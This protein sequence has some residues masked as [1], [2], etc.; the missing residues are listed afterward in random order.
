MLNRE[1][2]ILILLM[3]GVITLTSDL[4]S[5]NS[6]FERASATFINSREYQNGQISWAFIDVQSGETLAS[7]QAEK[8]QIPA[9]TVKVFT[10]AMLLQKL[11]AEATIKTNVFYHG[12]I[13]KHKLKGDIIVRGSGDP[14]L[15]SGLAGSMSGDSVLSKITNALKNLGIHKISG[16]LI[17][18]PY[19]LPYDHTV[20]PR[21]YIWEDI[22]NYYGAASWGLNWR[23]N[24]YTVQ[25]KT[26][27]SAPDSVAANI[28]SPWAN[29]LNL[30]YNIELIKGSPDDIYIYGGPFEFNVFAK[31]Q[32]Q[33]GSAAV[34][35]R[36]ALPNPPY[37]FGKE[38]I[39]YLRNAEIELDG[40]LII[41]K[42][43]H[44]ELDTI[45]S[46]ESPTVAQLVKEIQFN[47]NNLFAESLARVVS[48][49]KTND[50]PSGKQLM[51][52]LS[53]Y[54]S[55]EQ[56]TALLVDASGLSRNNLVGCAQLA[57]FLRKMAIDSSIFK[58]YYP[59]FPQSGKEGTVKSFPHIPGMRI[60]SGSMA[61]VRAY[62]GYIPKKNEGL[63]AFSIIVNNVSLPSETI[64][65]HIIELL[66]S[67]NE[68]DFKS[69]L[70]EK[71]Q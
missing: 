46:I 55:F 10:S 32:I 56:N 9:S 41:E 65:K 43:T 25:F 28:L 21:K 33:K 5:Q 30:K 22:G 54:V 71:P 68:S 18:D 44:Q 64:K 13:K 36:G 2:R 37:V 57:E 60:K 34:R 50:Y 14:S 11:G 61:N 62:C 31:G 47:S 26:D 35:E 59:S 52:W 15:G 69:R 23:N 8:L 40:E 7:Y 16:N 6:N 39:E 20:I 67:A 17:I 45:F 58:T 53:N 42:T 27:Y 12:Q 66:K 63:I 51:E 29:H 24:E 48:D 49:Y 70:I 4:I 1:W 19:I 38:F 3:I